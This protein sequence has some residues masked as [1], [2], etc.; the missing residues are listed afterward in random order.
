MISKQGSGCLS[1]FLFTELTW[2]KMEHERGIY[3]YTTLL[4]PPHN[5]VSTLLFPRGRWET[6]VLGM[7]RTLV[8]I[9]VHKGIGKSRNLT[10]FVRGLGH[11]KEQVQASPLEVCRRKAY[12]IPACSDLRYF[13]LKVTGIMRTVPLTLPWYPGGEFRNH[14]IALQ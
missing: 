6:Y 13:F 2:K 14:E 5:K 4:F 12:L 7:L 11:K 10:C 9:S 3:S 1:A 8:H